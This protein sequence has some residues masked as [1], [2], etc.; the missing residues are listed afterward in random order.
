MMGSEIATPP[1][2]PDG[3]A[4]ELAVLNHGE[5]RAVVHY[6]Q[7]LLSGRDVALAESIRDDDR[8]LR[9]EDHGAY[10]LVIRAEPTDGH[11]EP[12][13]NLYQV[14]RERHPDDTERLHWT[15]LGRMRDE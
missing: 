1:A 7:D 10:A 9:V 15:Y 5:L 11:H 3:L 8:V 4:S 2:L 13:R 14:T 12:T 6:A